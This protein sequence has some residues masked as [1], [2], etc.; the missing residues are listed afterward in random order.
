MV[1][2][3]AAWSI[4]PSPNPIGYKNILSAVARV[5]GTSSFGLVGT[6][7]DNSSQPHFGLILHTTGSAWTVSKPVQVG[8]D[9]NEFNAVAA[10]TAT[11]AW[12]VGDEEHSPLVEHWNGKAWNVITPPAG[13]ESLFAVKDFSATDVAVLDTFGDTADWNGK[14]W[15]VAV[16]PT[17]VSCAA[18]SSLRPWPASR[19]APGGSSLGSASTTSGNEEGL[20]WKGQLSSWSVNATLPGVSL[21]AVTPVSAT[22]IWAVGSDD[23]TGGAAFAHWNGMAW[24][25]IATPVTLTTVALNDVIRVPNTN[26]LWAVGGEGFAPVTGTAAAF[27]NGSAWVRV[28]VPQT[29]TDPNL[30]G[31]AAASS[32]NVYAVGSYYADSSQPVVATL[33]ERYH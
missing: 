7:F 3:A 6:D 27:Y 5:P 22:S 33:V 18:A 28:A 10:R 26:T 13:M 23:A 25:V 14:K 15:T 16:L 29:G 1:A 19:E 8:V 4:T 30:S 11:D 24:S 32:S 21:S 17:P 9:L 12:V 31:V 2:Q 20:V